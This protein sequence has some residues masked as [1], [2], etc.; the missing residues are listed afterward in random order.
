MLKPYDLTRRNNFEIISDKRK[1][2]TLIAMTKSVLVNELTKKLSEVGLKV[3][4]AR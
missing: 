2:T 1:T 4:E 3:L